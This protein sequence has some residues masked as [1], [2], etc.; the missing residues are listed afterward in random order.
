[1]LTIFSSMRPFV[2]ERTTR[3]QRNAIQSWVN[4]CAGCEILLIGS[5]A[6]VA[7]VASEFGIRHVPEVEC[8]PAGKP[9]RGAVFRQA[10]RYASFSRMCFVSADVLLTSDLLHAT[11][12]VSFDSSLLLGR[13][14]DLTIDHELAFHDPDWERR[15][16][17]AARLEGVLHGPSA[18]D[19]AVF[20]KDIAESMYPPFL[21]N[22]PGWDGWFIYQFKKRR[23]PVIDATETGPWSCIKNMTTECGGIERPRFGRMT[24]APGWSCREPAGSDL[25]TMREADWLLT[26]SGLR[27]PALPNRL[28]GYASRFQMWRT[29]VGAKRWVQQMT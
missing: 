28:L 24:W 13:R 4:A 29:A 21:I 9:I 23:I 12:A 1:M 5:E 10:C 8:G 14:T 20:P 15:L 25:L 16:R 7:E 27:R 3:A 18:V 2:D 17:E 11:G 6:G 26:A 19:W 22:H